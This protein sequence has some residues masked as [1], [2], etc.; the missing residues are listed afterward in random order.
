VTDIA[1]V[2]NPALQGFD[3]AMS[4]G[5]LL[6][7][8]GIYTSVILSL[9]LDAPAQPGDV[10]PDP[11][12]TDRRGWWGDAYLPQINGKPD[13]YGSRLW[14]LRRCAAVPKTASR[15]KQYA[16]EALNWMIEDGIVQSIIITC[17]FPS[18]GV[19]NVNVA[20]TGIAP[21]YANDNMPPSYNVPVLIAA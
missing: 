21:A 14:L 15:A 5:D 18:R 10:L 8:D 13:H 17:T 4:N 12:S 11:K 2:L 1:L 9:L 16:T 3:V 6:Q 19:L 7:D 20:F